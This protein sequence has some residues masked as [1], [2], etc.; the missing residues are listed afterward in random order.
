MPN[1]S[2]HGG[3]FVCYN[4]V[5]NLRRD[6]GLLEQNGEPNLNFGSV[7]IFSLFAATWVI[8]VVYPAM[9]ERDANASTFDLNANFHWIR[10][11]K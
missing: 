4:R 1:K 3:D 10:L 5:P 6:S 7:L 2:L 11:G 8:A 9:R